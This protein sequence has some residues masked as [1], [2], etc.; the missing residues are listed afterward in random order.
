MRRWDV[1]SPLCDRTTI[2][3][4]ALPRDGR[5]ASWELTGEDWSVGDTQGVPAISCQTRQN[6]WT[7]ASRDSL[8]QPCVSRPCS[9]RGAST[10]L[11]AAGWPTQHRVGNP[12]STNDNSPIK[13]AE[14]TTR[15]GALLE[16]N[17]NQGM[18]DWGCEG[19]RQPCLVHS[20]FLNFSGKIEYILQ[21]FQSQ[22]ERRSKQH[23]IL[24]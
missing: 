2:T 14:Q 20:E 18:P 24:W 6:K 10:T 23:L 12:E 11:A 5:W 16:L 7:R 4:R 19:K 3:H 8:K 9:S 15:R 21:K 13:A 1:L 22:R 17:H